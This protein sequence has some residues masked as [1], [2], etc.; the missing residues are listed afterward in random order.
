MNNILKKDSSV[1]KRLEAINKGLKVSFSKIREEIDIHLDS[2]NENTNEINANFEHILKVEKKVDKL[3]E[4]LDEIQML[5]STL[6]GTKESTYQQKFENI[7]LNPREQEVF[8]VLYTTEDE[9]TFRGIARRIGL[10][11]ELVEK[12]VETI[13]AK[14]VPIVRKYADSTTFLKLDKDFKDLQAK[15]N[16]LNLNEEIMQSVV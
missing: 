8:F 14:G 10:T 4:R 7:K 15:E 6:T 16:I 1:D 3:E 12:Y 2:I 11:P 9:L 5:I 13:I